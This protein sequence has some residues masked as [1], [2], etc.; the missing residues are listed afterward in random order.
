MTDKLQGMLEYPAARQG[1]L[2]P[3]L[4]VCLALRFYAT[5]AT[6]DVIGEMIGVSQSTASR[7]ITRV[8]DAMYRLVRVHIAMPTQ[9][10][11]ND[12]KLK[13]YQQRHFP[14]KY[15]SCLLTYS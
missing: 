11:A 8:T 15:D 5:G 9:A 2:P 1:S 10:E 7:T 13:F 14:G 3:V 4:Q 6:Q 12:Q